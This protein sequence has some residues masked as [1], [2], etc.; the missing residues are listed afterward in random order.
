VLDILLGVHFMSFLI[1]LVFWLQKFWK[2]SKSKFHLFVLR[3]S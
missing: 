3:I 1:V 2:E